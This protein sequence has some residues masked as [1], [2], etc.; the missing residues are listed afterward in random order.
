[1][2]ENSDRGITLNKGLAW[3][4]LATVLS[5]GIWIGTQVTD[6]QKG[7]VTL[8]NRQS[9][10]REAIRM[11]SLSINDLRSSNARIDERLIGIEST[12]Q[13]TETS[14]SEILRYLRGNQFNPNRKVDE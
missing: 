7:I 10:D 5:G 2:I 12:A 4:I 9:E 14:V 3:T 1:M 11:N 8:T 13:R 6:A